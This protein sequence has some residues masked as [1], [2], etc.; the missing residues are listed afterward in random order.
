[1]ACFP[2]MCRHCSADGFESIPHSGREQCLFVLALSG[3]LCL[4]LDRASSPLMG[5]AR[6][7]AFHRGEVVVETQQIVHTQRCIRTATQCRLAMWARASA[8][9]IW[10]GPLVWA[11]QTARGSPSGRRPTAASPSCPTPVGTGAT[12]PSSIASPSS[13]SKAGDRHCMIIL[14]RGEP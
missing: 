6:G 10:W 13:S 8:R 7:L 1:M 12:A 11:T 9:V 14:D 4:W 5:G 2:L 3:V